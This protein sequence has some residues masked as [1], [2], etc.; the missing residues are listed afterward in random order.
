MIAERCIGCPHPSQS[1][2][3]RREFDIWLI[4]KGHSLQYCALVG[5]ASADSYRTA[6]FTIC[7]PISFM[8]DI[9]DPSSSAQALKLRCAS[10]NAHHG[11]RHASQTW[12][13]QWALDSI[14]GGSSH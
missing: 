13:P 5:V 3:P 9:G 12:R 4:M 2:Q 11:H 1:L 7:E 8:I 6:R 10:L 14:G